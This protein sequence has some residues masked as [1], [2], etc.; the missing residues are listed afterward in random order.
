MSTNRIAKILGHISW[1]IFGL[2][3]IILGVLYIMDDGRIA[4]DPNKILDKSGIDFPEYTIIEKKDFMEREGRDRWY[5]YYYQAQFKNSIEARFTNL[6]ERKI[7]ESSSGWKKED[8]QYIFEENKDNTCYTT[9]TV[10]TL[11]G[12]FT[13]DY[14]WGY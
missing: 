14:E 7:N 1:E 4:N 6:L 13:I 12:T 3:M 5:T 8:N 2:V 10:N 11:E 9:I